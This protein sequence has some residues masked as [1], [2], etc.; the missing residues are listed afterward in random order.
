M[1]RSVATVQS[2]QSNGLNKHVA[3]V[4]SLIDMHCCDKN[5]TLNKK[6]I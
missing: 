4:S 5:D 3:N 1:H 6:I 2:L